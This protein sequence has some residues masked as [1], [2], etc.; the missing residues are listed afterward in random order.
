VWEGANWISVAQD[1]DQ[2]RDLVNKILKLWVPYKTG[3]FL[4]SWAT[5]SF[6][7]RT[8]VHEVN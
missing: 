6:S 7:R 1:R 5:I 2:F 8:P 3:N 4:T